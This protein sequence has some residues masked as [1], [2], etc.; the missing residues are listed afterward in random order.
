MGVPDPVLDRQFY[1]GVPMRR[2]TAFVVDALVILVILIGIAVLG[3]IIGALTLGLGF[4][5]MIPAFAVAGFFYRFT[6]LRE[7]SATLGMMLAG[8]ELRDAAGNRVDGPTAALH[9]LAF[10]TTL[11]LPVLMLAGMVWIWFNPHRRLLH[12]LPLGTVVINRPL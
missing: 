11:Y 10:Y 12:D 7:R 2:F 3:T 4:I 9:T 5:L 8:I 1:D 6:L